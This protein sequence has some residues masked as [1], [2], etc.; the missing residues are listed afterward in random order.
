MTRALIDW[1]GFKRE[2]VYFTAD[3]RANGNASYSTR[4]LLRLAVNSMVAMSLLPLKLA[5][6]GG[7]VIVLFSGS[8]GLFIF[9][10][11]YIMNDPWNL[12]FS[13]PAILAVIIV[14]LVGIILVCLGLM[15][16]YIASIHSEVVN[17]PLYVIR[18]SKVGKFIK[19]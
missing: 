2:Y 12:N 10:E 18:K 8:L 14:F 17:R 16:L 3:E 7:I 9:I 5:G 11:K 4:D 1:L 6:Y 13:G 15:A 19:S